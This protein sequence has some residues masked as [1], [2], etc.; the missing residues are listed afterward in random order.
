METSQDYSNKIENLD[1]SD[2]NRF[3]CYYET[4]ESKLRTGIRLIYGEIPAII[5]E[6]D[7]MGDGHGLERMLDSLYQKHDLT[8]EQAYALKDYIES[9]PGEKIEAATGIGCQHNS[10]VKLRILKIKGKDHS[11]YISDEGKIL[12]TVDSFTINNRYTPC[13]G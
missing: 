7:R 9:H 4:L 11:I 6:G 8:R 1:I 12:D 2:L 10:R 3:P 13:M 5:S